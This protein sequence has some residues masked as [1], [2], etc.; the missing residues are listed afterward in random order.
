MNTQKT[1]VM[2]AC[3]VITTQDTRK[4]WGCV[5]GLSV[6]PIKRKKVAQWLTEFP[7]AMQSTCDT[8]KFKRNDRHFNL[9]LIKETFIYL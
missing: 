8:Q 2:P 9:E 7:G 5:K 3:I 4:L 1:V 6:E